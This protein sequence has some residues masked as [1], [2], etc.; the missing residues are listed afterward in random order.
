MAGVHA[1]EDKGRYATKHII[2]E[3]WNLD[4]V[5]VG[6]CHAKLE[7]PC[8]PKQF[9]KTVIA[10]VLELISVK[11]NR[12][13]IPFRLAFEDGTL[14]LGDNKRTVNRRRVLVHL[15]QVHEKDFILLNHIFNAQLGMRMS[16]R[17]LEG[18]GEEELRHAR[19]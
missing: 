7:S 6:Q 12:F 13:V 3:V 10:E 2:N 5:L 4:G 15:S 9:P 18:R 1:K 17:G 8:L 19:Y 16:Q 14:H 11:I